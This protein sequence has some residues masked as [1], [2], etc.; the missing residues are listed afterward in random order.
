[1]KGETRGARRKGRAALLIALGALLGVAE[2]W[3]GWSILADNFLGA[4]LIF[5]GLGYCLGGGVWLALTPPD[6]VR[7]AADRSLLGFL[8][9]TLL[10]LVA[11]PLEYRF[12]P[13]MLPRARVMQGLGLVTI[14]L[15]M[16]LRIWARRSL[17]GAYQ[18]NLQVRP[19]QRLVTTGAY[20]RVRHPGYLAFILMALGLALGFSSLTGLMGTALLVFALRYRI[21]VEEAML[22]HAFGRAYTD[23]QSRT[24]RLILGVW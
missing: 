10:M 1:M 16:A 19:E 6:D 17:S 20:R 3:L 2:T 24:A 12:L 15:G 9:A 23:Y 13:A 4:F 7:G 5:I 8:P 18:G 21:R 14:V 11:M 22:V